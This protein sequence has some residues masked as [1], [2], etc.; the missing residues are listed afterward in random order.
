MVEDSGS[1]PLSASTTVSL[2]V[3]D[4]NDNP[5]IF[6]SS[7]YSFAVTENEPAGSYLGTLMVSDSDEQAAANLSF[8]LEGLY[9]DR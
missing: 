9:S 4:V 6:D 5:P 1:P 2:T 3:T 8:R 7:N